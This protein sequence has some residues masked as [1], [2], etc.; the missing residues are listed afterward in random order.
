MRGRLLKRKEQEPN[1][2]EMRDLVATALGMWLAD[3]WPGWTVEASSMREKTGTIH[4]VCTL[5]PPPPEP[6][7]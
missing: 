2:A 6:L 3:Q 7:H 4:V 5:K 1:R